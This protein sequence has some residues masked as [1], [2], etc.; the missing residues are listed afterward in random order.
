MENPKD[1]TEVLESFISILYSLSFSD[2]ILLHQK[3]QAYDTVKN[4]LDL[5]LMHIH[6]IQDKLHQ[7][8]DQCNVLENKLILAKK[9]NSSITKKNKRMEAIIAK[10]EKVRKKELLKAE[11]S[12]SKLS[13]ALE[14]L[15]AYDHVIK[16]YANDLFELAL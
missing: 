3:A 9:E 6:E 16:K 11:T 4:E 10:A 2:L 8:S 13:S 5:R 12:R 14:T 7:L 15:S 1:S